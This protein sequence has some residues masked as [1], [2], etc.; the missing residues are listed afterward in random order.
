[1]L[2]RGPHRR[3]GKRETIFPP[4]QASPPLRPPKTLQGGELSRKVPKTL[5]QVTSAPQVMSKRPVTLISLR[6]ELGGPNR[7]SR[8]NS[9]RG[10]A[11]CRPIKGGHWEPRTRAR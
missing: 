11:L 4:S 6:F 9:G 2:L 5:E 7:G 3:N 8:G 10:G 1:M